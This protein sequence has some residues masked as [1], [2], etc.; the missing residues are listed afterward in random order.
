MSETTENLSIVVIG[1]SGHLARTK[2]LPAL[3]ALYCQDFLPK[4]FRVIGFART[5]LTDAEFR[6]SIAENLTCRYTPQE[7]CED[8]MK[9]FLACCTYLAGQYDSTEDIRA[10]VPALRAAQDGAPDNRVFY[11]AVPP[12]VFLPVTHALG[13]AGFA[14]PPAAGTWCRVVIEKPFGHDRTSSDLLTMEMSQVFKEEQIYR[15]DHYLGK[16]VIQ[17]LLVLRFANAIFEP[18]W[19][20][21]YVRSVQ[22]TWKENLTIEGRGGYFD[23]SGIIRDVMQNHLLQILSLIAMEPPAR[24][25]ATHIRNAKVNALLCVPPPMLEDMAI[26]QYAATNRGGVHIPGYRDDPSVRPDSRTAT[27]AAAALRVVN[28][29]W[30]GVPFLLRA[31]KGLDG[32]VSEIRMQFRP[33]PGGMFTTPDDET[34]ELVI[35]IQPDEA[36]TFRIWSKVPGLEMDLALHDLD[37]QY[38]TKF[39]Q[40]IPDAYEDLLLDILRGEKSLFIREDE[41]AAAWDVFT[42]VLNDIDRRK[43]EPEPYEFGTHGPAGAD[44]LAKR[45]GVAWHAG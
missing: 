17:N 22:I 31:G 28:A 21:H 1:A 9:E 3:F 20:R 6:A 39:T 29:R 33:M 25:D 10:L 38:K 13:A 45:H 36:I 18:I 43:I 30:D 2:I 34:N 19:N 23:T 4:R 16:E 32:R 35:R 42:P 12:Q 44:R 24:L 15:I 5:P 27:Y 7:S 8:R 26:G 14:A 11:L 41:L 40:L 37:F